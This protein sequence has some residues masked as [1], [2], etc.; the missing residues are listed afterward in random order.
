MTDMLPVHYNCRCTFIALQV[1]AEVEQILMNVCIVTPRVYSDV[2]NSFRSY[3]SSQP[4]SAL[5]LA[6]IC[7]RQAMNDAPLPWEPGYESSALEDILS[8]VG[9]I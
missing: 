8:Q 9:D 6:T 1:P 7:H 2:L 3:L 4:Y 5:D